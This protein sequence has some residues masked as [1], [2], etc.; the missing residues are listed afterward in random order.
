MSNIMAVTCY[1]LYRSVIIKITDGSF[2]GTII[3][4]ST[5]GC[6]CINMT[7]INNNGYHYLNS[8]RYLNRAIILKTMI[9]AAAL[10]VL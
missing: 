3:S 5:E 8:N 4:I 1:N 9:D 10:I 2:N 7:H 6:H